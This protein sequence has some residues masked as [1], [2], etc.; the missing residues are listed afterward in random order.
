MKHGDQVKFGVLLPK[1]TILYCSI[2]SFT[3]VA[4]GGELFV[5]A[6]SY[7]DQWDR[8]CSPPARGYPTHHAGEFLGASPLGD[9]DIIFTDSIYYSTKDFC[10][11]E[12]RGLHKFTRGIDRLEDLFRQSV[13]R[14]EAR[15]KKYPYACLRAP[16]FFWATVVAWMGK[17]KNT[18]AY[19]VNSAWPSDGGGQN[20]LVKSWGFP[21]IRKNIGG[22]C[23]NVE[24]FAVAEQYRETYELKRWLHGQPSRH[25]TAKEIMRRAARRRIIK[26]RVSESD[27]QFFQTIFGVAQVGRW[28]K[29]AANKTKHDNTHAG[30]N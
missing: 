6:A 30:R 24:P 5:E 23:Y 7:E 4:E 15:E 14:D 8:V 13:C 9:G 12:R 19:L 16:E 21:L 10:F 11:R 3:V 20:A 27:I 22:S 18:P 17:Y 26:H 2:L 1:Q 29:E 28:I 25:D